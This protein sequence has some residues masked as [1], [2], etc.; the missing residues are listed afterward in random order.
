VTHEPAWN[1]LRAEQDSWPAPG[2]TEAGIARAQ[3]AIGEAAANSLRG[4]SLDDYHRI[5]LSLFWEFLPTTVKRLAEDGHIAYGEIGKPSANAHFTIVEPGHYAITFH[6]GLRTFVYRMARPI[7]AQLM[8]ADEQPVAFSVADLAR[9]I[10]EIIWWYEKTEASTGPI[11]PISQQ[12]LRLATQ[13]STFAEAFFIAHE[14]GHVHADQTVDWRS[15]APAHE[16]DTAEELFADATALRALMA[17]NHR[18]RVG[19][20]QSALAYAGAELGLRLWYSMECLEVSLVDDVHPPGARRIAH[21][22]A[23]LRSFCGDEEE[24]K[25]LLALPAQLE[26]LFEE[27]LQ[28]V[29]DKDERAA[30]FRREADILLLHFGRLLT[31]CIKP[32]GSVDRARF[33][34]EG[35][36]LVEKGYPTVVIERFIRPMVARFAEVMREPRPPGEPS[37]DPNHPVSLWR[38]RRQY[39]FAG[40]DLIEGLT[41]RL[42]EPTASLFRQAVFGALASSER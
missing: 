17:T 30:A 7:A 27:V 35:V 15:E 11:Y 16:L 24:Y 12:Q 9:V 20:E 32:E 34:A 18:A 3:N 39:A 26:R 14:F 10:A 23:A 40:F 2:I 33:N 29:L 28:I 8:R 6:T 41:R 1:Y 25:R 36:A 31:S 13:L 42:A 19:L 5:L 21:L 37:P 22:R 38:D 4:K